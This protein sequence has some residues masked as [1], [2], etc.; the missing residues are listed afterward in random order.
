MCSISD[1]TKK[2]SLQ[3]VT[4]IISKNDNSKSQLKRAEET[5]LL[6]LTEDDST[7]LQTSFFWQIFFLMQLNLSQLC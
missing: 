7:F 1:V 6:Q 5:E 2:E 3:R 4:T